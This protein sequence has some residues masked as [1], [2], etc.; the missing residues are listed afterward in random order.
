MS[1]GVP[2]HLA[3]LPDKSLA[4]LLEMSISLLNYLAAAAAVIAGI[5]GLATRHVAIALTVL[6]ARVPIAKAV[7]PSSPA[8]GAFCFCFARVSQG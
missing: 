2:S 3:S 5:E 4:G 1:N 7:V 8:P 6:R